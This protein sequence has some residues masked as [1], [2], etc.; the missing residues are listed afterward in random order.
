MPKVIL[1][2]KTRLD[3]DRWM[4]FYTDGGGEQEIMEGFNQENWDYPD[5]KTTEED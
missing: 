5:I 2:F 1:E 4:G 3:R